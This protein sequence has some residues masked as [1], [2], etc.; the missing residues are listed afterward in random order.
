M[1]RAYS[2]VGQ[3]RENSTNAVSVYSPAASTQTIIRSI[4][5]VNTTASAVTVRIFLD[6]NGTTYD[7]TTA[8]A[9]NVNIPGNSAWDREVTFC[10]N[11][12]AGNLAYRSS[13]A[14]ALTITVSALEI[15]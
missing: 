15:T 5:V 7:E 12:S 8:I 3:T 2:Q 10:M 11:D 1:P 6:D 4:V 9:W 14:N 13:V